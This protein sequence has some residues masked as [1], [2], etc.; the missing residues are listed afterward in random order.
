MNLDYHNLILEIIHRFDCKKIKFDSQYYHFI[1]QLLKRVYGKL[2]K[3]YSKNL[4]S[5][6]NAIYF[7]VNIDIKMQLDYLNKIVTEVRLGHENLCI[8][9]FDLIFHSSKFIEK[10]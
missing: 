7:I 10:N 2:I 3:I 8:I 1:M 4:C 9:S 6:S 5:D